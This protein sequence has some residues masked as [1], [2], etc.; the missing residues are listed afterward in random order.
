MDVK[1]FCCCLLMLSWENALVR[2]FS[3]HIFPYLIFN[4]FLLNWVGVP[5]K[6]VPVRANPRLYRSHKSLVFF[7]FLCATFMVRTLF[8]RT[9]HTFHQLNLYI[10]AFPIHIC[11]EHHSM[12]YRKKHAVKSGFSATKIKRKIHTPKFI[13]PKNRR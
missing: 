8:H 7:S 9:S 6:H 13:Q 4:Y 3:M 12:K 11:F 10:A 2:T 5:A 1:Q